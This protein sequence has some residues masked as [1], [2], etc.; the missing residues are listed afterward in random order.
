MQI[1]DRRTDMK[2]LLTLLLCLPGFLAGAQKAAPPLTY[3]HDI[4]PILQARCV[5]CHNQET[6]AN[7]A[8]SGGLALDT[9][10]AIRKGVTGKEGAKPIFTPGKAE[11]SLLERL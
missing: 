9:Y 6:L 8:A 4:K 10:A 7:P 11:S 3:A 1:S 2:W 5:V